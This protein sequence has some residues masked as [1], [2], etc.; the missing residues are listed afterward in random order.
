[1]TIFAN[2]QSL[3]FITVK[4]ENAFRLSSFLGDSDGILWLREHLKNEQLMTQY[5]S[6]SLAQHLEN[7]WF[8]AQGI[9]GSG[10]KYHNILILHQI[11]LTRF[12]LNDFI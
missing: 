1:M 8:Q 5:Y 10:S 12:F 11:I 2:Y 6:D 7:I 3:H 9:V 4:P